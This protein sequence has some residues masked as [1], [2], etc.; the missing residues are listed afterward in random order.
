MYFNSPLVRIFQ[1]L[2]PSADVLV[3]TWLYCYSY[4]QRERGKSNTVIYKINR[5]HFC[6]KDQAVPFSLCLACEEIVPVVISDHFTSAW[7]AC[8]NWSALVESTD[9]FSAICRQPLKVSTCKGLAVAIPD[10]NTQWEQHSASRKVGLLFVEW[11]KHGYWAA[12]YQSNDI[13]TKSYKTA[14][15]RYVLACFH[16][17]DPWLVR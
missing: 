11:S 8:G 6:G 10:V 13:P 3:S 16:T 17:L 7:S 12:V 9:M 1:S 2:L 15:V 5:T 14:H 4:T